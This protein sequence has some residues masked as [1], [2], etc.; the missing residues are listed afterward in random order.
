MPATVVTDPAARPYAEALFELAREADRLDEVAAELDGFLAVLR[1]DPTARE[2]FRSFRIQKA[3]KSAML[4]KVFAGRLS[5]TF[6]N[7]LKVTAARGRFPVIEDVGVVFHDLLDRHSGRVRAR[8]ATAVEPSAA[9]LDAVR[10][11]VRQRT[12]KEAVLQTA[13]KPEL[14]GG[15]VLELED[16]LIDASVATRLARLKAALLERGAGEVQTRAEEL[17]NVE[18]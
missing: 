5:E 3:E 15:F 1:G 14:I 6:L 12:G 7:F 8:L 18:G 9:E 10:Q 4:D 11:A 2:F 17:F 13:V 16:S